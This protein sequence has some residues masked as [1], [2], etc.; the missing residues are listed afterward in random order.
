MEVVYMK[1]LLLLTSCLLVGIACQARDLD[2]VGSYN[3]DEWCLPVHIHDNIQAPENAYIQWC[4]QK[5]Y[6]PDISAWLYLCKDEIN[7]GKEK[8]C[9]LRITDNLSINIVALTFDMMARIASFAATECADHTCWFARC[10]LSEPEKNEI[11]AFLDTHSFSEKADILIAYD[12]L[13]RSD[14]LVIWYI[15][16]YMIEQLEMSIGS[17]YF[18]HNALDRFALVGRFLQKYYEQETENGP[19]KT[20]LELRGHT[21]VVNSVKFSSDEQ[22]VITTAW[23]HEKRIWNAETGVQE[24]EAAF[25][26]DLET[27][28][29]LSPDRK[30]V[31][32][33]SGKNTINICNA[34]TCEQEH[35]LKGHS[36]SIMSVKFSPDGVH[37]VTASSDCTARVWNVETGKQEQVLQGHDNT[38]IS[39]MFSPDNKHI[40]TVSSDCTARVWDV[41]TGAIKLILKGHHGSV[42]ASVFSPDGKHIAT[43]SHD[44]TAR[45]W[46]MET[47]KQEQILKGHTDSVM[48]VAFSKNGR[49]IAT[50]SW[51]STVRIWQPVFDLNRII[52]PGVKHHDYWCMQLLVLRVL[53]YPLFTEQE[54]KQ[55]QPFM[56]LL[57]LQDS[58]VY[59]AICAR[60]PVL[61][62]G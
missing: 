6:V 36:D 47:G 34:E 29:V 19:W 7:A 16:S 14:Y 55:L 50:A 38:V 32:I 57:Q 58:N 62:N 35:E 22:H 53:H 51:D 18:D 21:D 46:N 33:I 11:R 43:A 20:V 28:V 13:A 48:S 39:A 45:I 37:V 9:A 49:R 10:T 12:T 60:V 2:L 4:G 1:K 24:Y 5:I 40:V 56:R 52:I 42:C 54:V 59:E 41:E 27:C 23:N 44:N 61:R 17:S 31:A 30:H 3:G 8:R 15:T 26:P 25:S